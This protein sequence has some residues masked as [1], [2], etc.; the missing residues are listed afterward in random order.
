MAKVKVAGL[1]SAHR[2]SINELVK[3]Q[4]EGTAPFLTLILQDKAT[5]GCPP[6]SLPFEVFTARGHQLESWTFFD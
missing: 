2:L 4:P 6:F 1:H 3:K 5:N